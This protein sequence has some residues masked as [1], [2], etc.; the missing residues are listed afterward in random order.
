MKLLQL[1]SYFRNGGSF[2]EF[3]ENEQLNQESEVIEIYMKQ[4]LEIN[5]NLGFFEIEKTEGNY[6]FSDNGILY[7]NLFD[8]YYFQDAIEESNDSN[9][10]HLTDD[11]IAKI[12]FNYAIND[13]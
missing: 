3:C 1:V 7:S 11:Q 9:N 5:S 6:E 13:A 12:L 8:F 10:K 4:P 2:D